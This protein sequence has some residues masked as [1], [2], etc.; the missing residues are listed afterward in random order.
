MN[1]CQVCGA[2]MGD[3]TDMCPFCLNGG[4]DDSDPA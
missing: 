1:D 2:D 4:R 3:E